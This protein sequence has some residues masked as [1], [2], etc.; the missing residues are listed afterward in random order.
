VLLLLNQKIIRIN[1]YIVYVANF[2]LYYY[3]Y[4][5]TLFF[6]DLPFLVIYVITFI[7]FVF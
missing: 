4:F 6:I 5:I 2:L 1:S 3:L 7:T